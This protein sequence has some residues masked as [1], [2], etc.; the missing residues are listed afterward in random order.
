MSM[1]DVHDMTEQKNKHIRRKRI[2]RLTMTLIF[3]AVAASVY[4][5]HEIWLPKLR[6]LGKQYTTIVNDGRLAEGNFPIEINGGTEYQMDCS[7]KTVYVL[8][9]SSIYQYNEEGGLIHRR[10]HTYTNTIMNT[11][12]GMALLY[13]HGGNHFSVEDRSGVLYSKELEE[14][15]RLVRLSP[16][17]YTAVV[18]TSLN[19]ECEITIFD[20]DG[21]FIYERKCVQRVDDISFTNESRGCVISYINAENGSLVTSVQKVTFTESAEKWT[22]PGLDTLGVSV[23]GFNGGAVVIG[24]D[25][26]GYVDDSGQIVSLYHYEGDFAGGDCEDGKSAVIINSDE[27]RKYV[28][29]LFDGGGKE[30]L[31]IGFNSP[32]VDVTVKDGLAYVMTHDA[33]LAY[34]FT[35]LLRST[36]SINDS[37]TG[38]ARSG[39]YIFLKSFSKIDRINYES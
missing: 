1:Y 25:A 9:D 23:F 10:Q 31:I 26:C 4:L 32:L 33:V 6:G 20:R 2:F 37:Y 30:P 13:E 38:F 11:A 29:A 8:S 21:N 12:G 14:N 36:A 7:N 17:G 15:I 27:T 18:T 16:E 3:I 35:G 39:G 5:T 19:Y 34:D 28:M 24:I 22:S